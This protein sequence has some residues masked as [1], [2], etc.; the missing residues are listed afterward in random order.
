[1]FI[2]QDKRNKEFLETD[3]KKINDPMEILAIYLKA[4]L[5]NQKI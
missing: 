3:K 5:K 4:I 1:M 2:N